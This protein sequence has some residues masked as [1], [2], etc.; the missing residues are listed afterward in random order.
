MKIMVRS[1]RTVMTMAMSPM[2]MPLVCSQLD[3]DR[4]HVSPLINYI[5]PINILWL[6]RVNVAE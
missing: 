3:T 6:S 4:K 2:I 1:S 5:N